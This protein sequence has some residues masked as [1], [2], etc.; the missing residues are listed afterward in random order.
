MI[1]KKAA[2][3][4]GLKPT[5]VVMS[6]G[7][8]EA[9]ECNTYL[10]TIWLP[11][12][13]PVLNIKVTEADSI[14]GGVDALIGMDIITQGD[15]SVTHGQGSTV[16]SFRMPSEAATDSVQEKKAPIKDTHHPSRNAKCS[17]G[18]GLKYKKCC[19]K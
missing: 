18:S 17:C 13:V 11:N 6:Q 10:A 5:G 1:T 16:F 2:E 4:C 15:F 7:V 9:K 3:Q 8:H 12:H 19:G 14:T